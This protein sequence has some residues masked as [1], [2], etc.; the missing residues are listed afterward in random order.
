MP[1]PIAAGVFGIARTKA[2]AGSLAERSAMRLP[3]R[4]ETTSVSGPTSFESF[5]ATLSSICGLIAS[6][7]VPAGGPSG[8]APQSMKPCASHSAATSMPGCGSTTSTRPGAPA[9]ASP[10]SSA[11][12]ILP[13]PTKTILSAALSCVTLRLSSQNLR[14][15]ALPWHSCRPR[16]RIGTPD[17]SARRSATHCRDGRRRARARARPRR[18]A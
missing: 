4:I 17:S 10:E 5:G 9:R 13:A 12:P 15:P 7:K 11:A 8:G 16:A 1:R 18:R 3:A 6:S 2:L 14:P